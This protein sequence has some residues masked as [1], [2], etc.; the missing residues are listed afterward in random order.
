M[1]HIR[2]EILLRLGLALSGLAILYAI[3]FDAIEISNS[4]VSIMA[5]AAWVIVAFRMPVKGARSD[6]YRTEPK[7]SPYHSVI[8]PNSM[9]PLLGQHNQTRYPMVNS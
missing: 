9:R 5:I 2:Y 7:L 1:K 4:V 3:D 6:Q 8:L